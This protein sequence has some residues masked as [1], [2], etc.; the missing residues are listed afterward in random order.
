MIEALKS[1]DYPVE[2]LEFILTRLVFNPEKRQ[3]VNYD[4]E[5]LG[6]GFIELDWFDSGARQLLNHFNCWPRTDQDFTDINRFFGDQNPENTDV[7]DFYGDEA[8]ILWCSLMGYLQ[9]LKALDIKQTLVLTET[10][11]A[12]SELHI[13]R[14]YPRLLAGIARST[15]ECLQDG[16]DLNKF[17]QHYESEASQKPFFTA[18]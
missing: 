6:G 11:L 3:T 16:F 9:L 2:N 1:P 10:I 17:L 15:S 8:Q 12:L 4:F 14:E 18:W 7:A 5:Y 13:G